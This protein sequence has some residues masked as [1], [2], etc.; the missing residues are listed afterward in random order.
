MCVPRWLYSRKRRL[1]DNRNMRRL[2]NR[3]SVQLCLEVLEDRTTPAVFNIA[4]G[5]VASLITDINLEALT[6][7][8]RPKVTHHATDGNR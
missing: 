2:P 1:L 4:T 6:K 7:P 3:R 5:D 8:M